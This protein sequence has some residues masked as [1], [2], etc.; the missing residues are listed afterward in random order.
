M[1]LTPEEKARILTEALP[2]IKQFHGKTIVVKYGGRAMV[3]ERLKKSVI[4]DIVLLFLVGIKVVLVH[5]GGP[6]IDRFLKK[7]NIKP[8]FKDGLRVTDEQ[9]ME[10]V[11]MVLTGK[12]NK[13][14]VILLRNQGIPAIGLS[15]EDANLLE[16]EQISE[17]LGL[18]GRVSK[19]RSEIINSIIEDG[20]LPVIATTALSSD[21]KSLNVNAD[22]AAA[23]IASE[24]GAEKLI[25]LTDVDGVM[26]EDALVS[27]LT[28]SKAQKLLKAGKVE[29]G[30]RPKLQACMDAISSGVKQAHILNGT[31]KHAL[32]LELFTDSGIGTMITEG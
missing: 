25:F 27:K 9:T 20:F 6:Q 24:M 29:G 15:G 13:E 19:V 31:R 2:Y 18:V 21:G 11:R 23:R 22:E 3:E 28:V 1:N 14:L 7:L 12:I 4:K 8:V 10:V 5:G 16:A 30:M 26:V 32:I 17:E